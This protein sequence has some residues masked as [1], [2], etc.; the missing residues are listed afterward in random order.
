MA[1]SPKIGDG[2][3]VKMLCPRKFSGTDVRDSTMSPI[4]I[5]LPMW[6]YNKLSLR[7][8][9]TYDYTPT[10]TP[11]FNSD[12]DSLS[13]IWT[14]TQIVAKIVGFVGEVLPDLQLLLRQ[15]MCS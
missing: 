12:L 3:Y 4:V 11:L 14:C 13:A 9:F 7:V 6:L 2:F 10:Q 1:M 8:I 15:Y 5:T